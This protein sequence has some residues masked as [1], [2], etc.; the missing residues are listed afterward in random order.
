MWLS[1]LLFSKFMKIECKILLAQRSCTAFDVATFVDAVNYYII[2][3]GNDCKIEADGAFKREEPISWSECFN[4]ASQP[5]SFKWSA[6][7]ANSIYYAN[8]KI[9]SGNTRIN[10]RNIYSFPIYL[11]PLKYQNGKRWADNKAFNAKTVIT[12]TSSVVLLSLFEPAVIFF[13]KN[14][15]YLINQIL[16]FSWNAVSHKHLTWNQH[17]SKIHLARF[18]DDLKLMSTHLFGILCCIHDVK[19]TCYENR[20]NKS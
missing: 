4:L 17:I 18:S 11:W 1:T 9:T 3:P 20:W 14:Q 2:V 16:T 7:L 6:Q 5:F 13:I 10:S 12:K 19:C 8:H 15:A